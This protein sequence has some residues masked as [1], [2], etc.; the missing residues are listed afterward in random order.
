MYLSRTRHPEDTQFHH[1]VP[2]QVYKGTLSRLTEEQR[3]QTIEVR[4][5]LNELGYTKQE[6]DNLGLYLPKYESSYDTDRSTHRG[7]S[8]SHQQYNKDFVVRMK[9]VLDFSRDEVYTQEQ[10]RE[11]VHET[12]AEMRQD[13]RTGDIDVGP[14]TQSTAAST[15]HNQTNVES[16]T[17]SPPEGVELD[18]THI[19]GLDIKNNLE[20]PFVLR[21]K[22]AYGKFKKVA[23]EI[24]CMIRKRETPWLSLT[25]IRNRYMVVESSC[26]DTYIA[27]AFLK[28]DYAM[29]MH[30]SGAEL[31]LPYDLITEERVQKQCWFFE[32]V[33]SNEWDLQTAIFALKNHGFVD[34]DTDN[35]LCQKSWNDKKHYS[36]NHVAEERCENL[37]S[38]RLTVRGK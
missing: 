19:V 35:A 7:Y 20:F 37:V 16:A 31:M 21:S 34:V 18:R 26:H 11:L 29:K 15:S 22:Y 9:K 2:R 13:I 28:L 17:Y 25:N 30:D 4:N 36:E 32:K 14:T 24:D 6:T 33:E 3:E 8:S 1:V 27:E 38:S 23:Y 12:L 10:T 5:F